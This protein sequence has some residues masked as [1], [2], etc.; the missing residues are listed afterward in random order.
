[1]LADF[2]VFLSKFSPNIIRLFWI[3]TA[4]TTRSD[5]VSSC[6]YTA[7]TPVWSA[8]SE[9]EPQQGADAVGK[10]VQGRVRETLLELYNHDCEEYDPFDI[11]APCDGLGRCLK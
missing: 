3:A 5:V 4:P 11:Q 6:P 7:A 8:Y 1:M 10:R 2:R 9:G